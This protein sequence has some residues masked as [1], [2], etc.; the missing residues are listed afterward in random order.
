MIDFIVIVSFLLTVW[1]FELIN[2]GNK[3]RYVSQIPRGNSLSMQY[4]LYAAAF[5]RCHRHRCLV[6]VATR[7]RTYYISK[8]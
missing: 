7:Q 5:G 6:G 3:T 1:H 8:H 2:F 4:A